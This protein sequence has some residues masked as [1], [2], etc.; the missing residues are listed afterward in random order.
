M[1]DSVF[2]T[3]LSLARRT[4]QVPLE[5]TVTELVAAWI[6][7]DK[8]AF[9]CLLEALGVEAA[10]SGRDRFQ[11]Q[12]QVRLP[13]L[14]EHGHDC[15][16][17]PDLVLA[18]TSQG[19]S[20]VAFVECKVDAEEGDGQLD[21]YA[22]HLERQVGDR[23]WLI[24]L[25]KRRVDRERPSGLSK[26]SGFGLRRWAHVH[27]RMAAYSPRDLYLSHLIRLLEQL[28]MDE[29]GRFT[30]LDCATLSGLERA[31]RP[32]DATLDGIEARFKQTFDLRKNCRYSGFPQ[33]RC[34]QNPDN[35]LIDIGV[36]FNLSELTPLV[37]GFPDMWVFLG[38]YWGTPEQ[39]EIVRQFVD[40]TV[41]AQP[42]GE[43]DSGWRRYKGGNT[44]YP[45]VERVCSLA[46]LLAEPN[47]VE[48][49]QAWMLKA[50]ED[51][52]VLRAKLS[53]LLEA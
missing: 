13:R 7:S 51:L 16:S 53:S 44:P 33:R 32:F 37:P 26:E 3:C 52:Q 18:W 35:A 5:D 4:G 46:A 39:R 21:R 31:F 17:I 36:G 40:R 1:T 12:T 2:Y 19:V 20:C 41:E 24:F 45:Y 25:T 47:A 50:I 6:S 27:R 42:G 23:R 38:A 49:A 30:S 28:D 22:H 11:V 8:A 34:L 43:G 14:D 9:G 29:P 15:D 10:L 48:R